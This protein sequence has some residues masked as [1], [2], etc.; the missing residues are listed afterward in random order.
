MRNRYDDALNWIDQAL[1]MPTAHAYPAL[2]A[3][4][5]GS[6]ALAL[7]PLGR[8]PELSA[9]LAQAEAIARALADPLILSQTLAL[10]SALDEAESGGREVAA[11]IAGEALDLAT[12]ADDDWAIAMAALAK[13]WRASTPAELCERVDRAAGL[14]TEAGNAFLLA[15]LLAGSV[16]EALCMRADREAKE[17][18]DRAT[19][20]ARGLDD[21][22]LTAVLHANSG[23]AALLTGD[24]GAAQHAFREGLQLSG[25]LVIPRLAGT[26]LSGLAAV[27]A[28]RKDTHRAA[29]LAGAA[30]AHRD[31][32]PFDEV[33][34]RLDEIFIEPART[35]HGTDAWNAAARDGATLSLDDAIA[36]DLQEP[37]T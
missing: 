22:Y 36:Y 30:A 23:M 5:L 15:L 2:R 3:R 8:G 7:W 1:S 27:A 29:R 13:A 19:P 25:R 31:N 12:A 26:G 28:V 11:A 10:R 16:Y 18:V 14:L 33:E 37:L 4:V 24:P 21:P 17:L 20:L 9:A 35:C 6:K 34:A 32:A